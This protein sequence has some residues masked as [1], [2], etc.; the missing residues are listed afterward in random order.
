MLL[1]VC[2][3]NVLMRDVRAGTR[4][5]SASDTASHPS[6]KGHT[7]NLCTGRCTRLL[8][9][10]C[11][12]PTWSHP[13]QPTPHKF[14]LDAGLP[15]EAFCTR[16][17]SVCCVVE[18]SHTLERQ[19]KPATTRVRHWRHNVHRPDA[20]TW[21]HLVPKASATGVAEPGAENCEAR[22]ACAAADVR[23]HAPD[24]RRCRRS[25]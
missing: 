8:A 24:F 16:S 14:G 1:I 9:R 11:T 17:G 13:Q 22:S 23:S 6:T 7:Y 18:Q 3:V 12:P 4:H 21:T 5:T 15:M 10:C 19:S 20:G 2:G 25:H